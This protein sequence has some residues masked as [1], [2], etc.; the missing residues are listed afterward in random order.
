[1]LDIAAVTDEIADT[2]AEALALVRDWGLTRIELREGAQ[3]RYPAFTPEEITMLE[4]TR[5]DGVQVTAV[6][7]GLFKGSIR[8]TAK[9]AAEMEALPQ[10]LDLAHRLGCPA[11]IIFGFERFEDDDDSLRPRVVEAFRRIAE[12]VAE[13]GMNVIVE[14]EPGFWMDLPEESAALVRD[15]DHPAFGLNWDPANLHWGGVLPTY[16]GFRTV[17]P[18]LGGLHVKDYFPANPFAPWCAVGEGTTPW[19]DILRW[20]VE[21]SG[22]THVTLET[23]AIP[24][25]E[26]SRRSLEWMRARIAEVSA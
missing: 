7:P 4:D 6:S 24:R 22:L 5:R 12:T 1:M 20:A 19:A 25:T 2:P 10:S 3:A 8:D 13:A 21:E 26:T 14:N 15:V 11:L 18:Y 17:K 16:E 9:L 23:H